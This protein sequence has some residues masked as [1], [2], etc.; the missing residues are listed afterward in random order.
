MR[1]TSRFS[2]CT[3]LIAKHYASTTLLPGKN[4]S[5]T[6]WIG[7]LTTA[8]RP[9]ETNS[10]VLRRTEIFTLRLVYLCSSEAPAMIEFKDFPLGYLICVGRE[11]TA[12]PTGIQT[13]VFHLVASFFISL[14]RFSF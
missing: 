8:V 5:G 11:E 4:F 10:Q 9:K 3:Q 7:V 6:Q 12:A 14:I 13:I 1:L 2:L